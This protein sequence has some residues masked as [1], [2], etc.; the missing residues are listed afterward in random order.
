MAQLHKVDTQERG[1]TKS[2]SRARRWCFTINNYSSEENDTLTHVFCEKSKYIMGYEIGKSG[3][4][5]IQGYVEFKNGKSYNSM[6]KLMPRAHIE[7]TKGSREQ[8]IQ[9]CSKSNNF[10]TN[11][12]NIKL[13]I[14]ASKIIYDQTIKELILKLKIKNIKKD[15]PN[16]YIDDIWILKEELK[17]LI[18]KNKNLL[19]KINA[20]ILH[21]YELEL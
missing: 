10:K 5:H 14:N 13:P 11:F 21:K 3:T 12:E 1:N 20:S 9:Y 19:W 17:K 2:L 16:N 18:K 7:I 15:K 4:K 6:K 8:N